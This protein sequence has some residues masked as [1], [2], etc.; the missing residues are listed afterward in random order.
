VF[1]GN[2]GDAERTAELA[3]FLLEPVRVLGLRATVHGV[4]YPEDALQALARAGIRYGGWVPN[5][6]V[7]RVLARHGAGVHVPRRPYVEAL[8]GIPTIRV[9]EVLACGVPLVSA[10]WEDA[11]ALFRPGRDFLVARGG[12]E[13]VQHLRAL[14]HEPGL[15]HA[16][17]RSGLETVRL[18]HTIGHRVDELLSLHASL[19][20]TT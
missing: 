14:Q 6:R 8:P 3:E 13:M 10:P 19:G 1:V 2:W 11:E 9:F 15:A 17:A 4:R 12:A 18:R 16:L 7:P 5:H 20:G